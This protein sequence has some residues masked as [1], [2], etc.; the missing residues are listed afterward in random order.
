MTAEMKK[1]PRGDRNYKE[2]RMI[3]LKKRG[4]LE[5]V[6]MQ[7]KERRMSRT[8]DTGIIGKL[9]E[10]LEADPM[11]CAEL[12]E[13]AELLDAAITTGEREIFPAIVTASA[14]EAIGVFEFETGP[15]AQDGTFCQRL[16]ELHGQALRP[17]YAAL[18]ELL[19]T[20][21]VADRLGD[22]ARRHA[23]AI[24][25]DPGEY[26]AATVGNFRR[27]V[28]LQL[29]LSPRHKLRKVAAELS[30]LYDYAYRLGQ[31]RLL[32][33]TDAEA[34]AA[35][36]AAQLSAQNSALAERLIAIREIRLEALDGRRYSGIEAAAFLQRDSWDRR[37]EI[38]AAL[39]TAARNFEAWRDRPPMAAAEVLETSRAAWAAIAREFNHNKEED[40]TT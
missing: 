3:K 21:A 40:R 8:D 15:W 39:E 5:H 13:C 33:A 10:R 34:V 38:R 23:G 4:A 17:G 26:S 35:D 20:T 31:V 1:R 9:I 29:A 14:G 37:P 2:R 27:A 6:V 32:L 16:A 12:G 24:A 25:E 36:E 19:R 18:A 11:E 30:G 7:A 28:V 22:V